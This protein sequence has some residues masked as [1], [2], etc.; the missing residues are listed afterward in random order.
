MLRRVDGGLEVRREWKQGDR[1]LCSSHSRVYGR[2][3][4]NDNS[5]DGRGWD[6]GYSLEVGLAELSDGLHIVSKEKL[7][8][9]DES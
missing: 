7:S 4:Q 1:L 5:E 8:I 2:V 6:W 9:K 3:G